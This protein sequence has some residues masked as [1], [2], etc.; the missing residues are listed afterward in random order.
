MRPQQDIKAALEHLQRDAGID[1]ARVALWGT[2]LG[3][4]HVLQEAG[5]RT[6]RAAVGVQCPL[7]TD[8]HGAKVVR[9]SGTAQDVHGA[10]RRFATT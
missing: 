2:S 5:Q 6:D 9:R 8:C 4:M 1:S 7:R 10:Q 3:A